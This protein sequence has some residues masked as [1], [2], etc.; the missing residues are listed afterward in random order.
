VCLAV[1]KGKSAY[2]VWFSPLDTLLARIETVRMEPFKNPPVRS[3]LGRI[4]RG[5]SVYPPSSKH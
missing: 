2:I 5:F 1:C 3:C 4:L